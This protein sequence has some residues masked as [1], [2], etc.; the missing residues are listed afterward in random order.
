V[1]RRMTRFKVDPLEGRDPRTSQ[2]DAWACIIQWDGYLRRQVQSRC[3]T[4]P[5]AYEPADVEQLARELSLRQVRRWDPDRLSLSAWTRQAMWY[6]VGVAIARIRPS[7]SRRAAL[8]A[9]CCERAWSELVDS[10]GRSPTY[11]EVAD[12]AGE[13]SRAFAS[14][15]S[16]TLVKRWVTLGNPDDGICLQDPASERGPGGHTLE[17]VLSEEGIEERELTL[18]RK[19]QLTRL[20]AALQAI[21]D[22][23]TRQVMVLHHVDEFTYAD[24]ASRFDLTISA[25]KQI[26]RSCRQALADLIEDGGMCDPE[27]WFALDIDP[28]DELEADTTSG[29]DPEDDEELPLDFDLGTVPEMVSLAARHAAPQPTPPQPGTQP[30][31]REND[32]SFLFSAF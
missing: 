10:L 25:V 28:G 3:H 20:R 16:P 9:Q 6:S 24:I 26:E 17:E 27:S 15:I 31:L 30:M 32:V 2:E 13:H 8:I 14:R 11:E 18:I 23:R 21:P 19:L 29:D 5:P 7:G 4:L 12:L 1:P 22:E